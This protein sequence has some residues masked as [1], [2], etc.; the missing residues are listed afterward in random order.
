VLNFFIERPI[1]S[2][3]IS[4]VILLAG[5]L[6]GFNL[7]IA[8][9]PQVVPPQ[10]QVSTS[11]PGANAQVVAE[12]V[13]APIE[14]QVN[15]AKDMIY[16]DSKSGADGSYSLVVSF[17]IGT[18]P[19]IAAVDVQNRYAIAQSQL[20]VDVSRQG[21]TIRK[22]ST[23]FLEV[24]AL[25]AP[26]GR[27]DNV[28]LSN[29]ATLNLVDAITRISGVGQVRVFGARD[30]SMR[31]WLDPDRM[32]RLGVTAGDV[33]NAIREQNVVV[34]GGIIG[35][36]P[37]PQGTQM[38]YTVNV[39]GRLSDVSQYESMIVRGAPDG[40]I[41]RLR[42]IARVELSGADYS[43]TAREAQLPS[44]FIGIFLS[45]GA[46]ALDADQGVRKVMQD[47]SRSFPQGMVYSIPYTTVPFVTESLKEVAKTLG[48]A[49]VLVAFVVFLFLQSWR[50]TIIP[51]AAV[52][53]SLIGT[54]AA[55][56]A[57]GF[58]INTLTLFGLVLAIG[59]VVDDAIV[60]VEAVQHR[61]D[62]EHQS[63]LEA[64]KGAIAD[65]GGPV[66]AIALVL[67]AVFVPVAFLGGLAG[68]LYRQFALTLAVSVVLSALCAL[69]LTPALC[70]ILL[71]PAR[72]GSLRRS[73]LAPFYRLFNRGFDG[74][75]RSYLRA[76][77]RLV[78]HAA[79]VF[80]AFAAL[81]GVL[82]WQV[83][84]RP[85]SL[86]PDED[87]GFVLGIVQLPLGASTERSHE[88][89]SRI[90][91]ISHQVP[92]VQAMA[93]LE[94]FNLFT[95]IAS[96]F[97]A[98]FF[99]RLKP[100]AD[101]IGKP[102]QSADEIRLALTG[103][104]NREIKGAFG[105]VVNPPPIRG[106]GGYGGFEFVLQDRSGSGLSRFTSTLQD[107]LT[108]ARQRPEIGFVFANFDPRVPQIEYAVDRDRAKSIGVDLAD[109]NFA[110]QAFLGSY[111]VNDFNLYGRT[112]RVETQAEAGARAKPEDIARMY[113][114]SN[115]GAM[116]PLSTLV[117]TRS[118]N[119]PQY[120][121]RYNIYRAATINFSPAARYTSGQAA[122]AMED[123]AK[124]LPAGFSY[125]WTGS[126]FQEKKTGG[127]TAYVFALSLAFVFL[128]LA[129]L[130][131]SWSMPVAILLVIPFGV[132]GAF[133]A[134]L[135]RGM[136]NDVYT[137][138]GLIMLI[139][140][141]AKN[142]ILIVEFAKVA[143]ERG[144]SIM[145]GAIRAAGLRLRPI[146]MT[147]FAFIFGSLPLAIASGA[148]AG[149]RRSIGTAVVSGMLF[150]TMIGI[151]LIPVF[152]VVMQ[153]ISEG[154]LPFRPE[155]KA[156]KRPRA[157]QASVPGDGVVDD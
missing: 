71:R 97:N 68:Q 84:E 73:A 29:Y 102:G 6:A 27:Y 70:A 93:G 55:F 11:F 74:F 25:T 116:V 106:M 110:L 95:G 66:I 49:F 44:A 53:V 59:I 15:G 121:E 14:Q 61:I 105:V 35:G 8:Q 111:Y 142:A 135:L 76:V 62:S 156:S 40:Q 17:E 45:P 48:I 16:M 38:T 87:Q 89:Y 92:G 2:T 147:S 120:L 82:Y 21:V 33:A 127:K 108:R 104:I 47:S 64:T 54:F 136:P 117:S 143:H 154:H 96:P 31:V 128:V 98:S 56:A 72:E 67:A 51:V 32:A 23:D 139:G 24:F 37:A 52:P 113:V 100:W 43:I 4:L 75:R 30:Y 26:D 36:P 130:Y 83:T 99:I 63:P 57:L 65:V 5:A 41:V 107:F 85:S 140:L 69:T 114:R 126:E 22:V 78:H 50:A 94:G 1:F 81:L 151:F 18:N 9:Y 132:T 138:I 103:R 3:V 86:V 28:F 79:L 122:A 112:Y 13:A 58:S 7:P 90:E 134:L 137:Q 133:A 131:E 12:S 119:G 91:Q 77:D 20:P 88:V 115:A 144:A 129:A 150:A 149:A 10:V 42:D 152:Y 125:E 146:L 46:N 155:D 123:L 34:P 157:A 109:V 145:D 80:L 141:A 39:L 124:G 148:G 118:V 60:V 19:D 153:R 101:R